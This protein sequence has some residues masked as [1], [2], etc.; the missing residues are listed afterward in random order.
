MAPT[1]NIAESRQAGIAPNT[2]YLTKSIA[3]PIA[4]MSARGDAASP[5]QAFE[6][7]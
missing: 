1:E 6:I 4:M 7:A 2:T 5:I 3:L